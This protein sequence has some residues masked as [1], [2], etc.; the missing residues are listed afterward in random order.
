MALINQDTEQLHHEARQLYERFGQL[1][2]EIRTDRSNEDL[3][4][5]LDDVQTPYE[6]LVEELT[7]SGAATVEENAHVANFHV[8]HYRAH[9]PVISEE[10]DG[11]INQ[12]FRILRPRTLIA[13]LMLLFLG[14]TSY[15][16]SDRSI[17]FFVVPS[18][19]MQPTLIPDDKLVTFR[20]TQYRRGDIIVLNDP[21]EE[22]AF[23]VKRLVALGNDDIYIHDG[24]I[25][26]NSKPVEE[27]YINGDIVYE[28]G[29]YR[30]PEGYIF[31]LGDNRNNSEDGHVW[32]HGVPEDSIVGEVRYIYSPRARA[33]AIASGS[34]NFSFAG[35]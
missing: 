31:V 28:F 23:L 19:S 3:K 24:K 33:G 7:Q 26:V 30:V 35:L 32:K 21:E 34:E 5:Q 8:G 15:L 18:A 16:M 20:K 6:A 13:L 10:G 11:R 25:L 29:P 1:K 4:I 12:M 14:S 9:K 22:G 2:A 17:G 27:S